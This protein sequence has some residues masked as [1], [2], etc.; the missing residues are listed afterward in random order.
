MK[1]KDQVLSMLQNRAGAYVSGQEIADTLF[2]TRAGIWKAIRSLR[3]EGHVIEAVNNRGYRL[4]SSSDILSEGSIRAHWDSPL[5][6][7]VEDTVESTNDCA[8]AYSR[9]G[10]S[11]EA[12]FVA[13]C[14]TKGRGRRGRAFYSPKDT[15]LYLSILLHPHTFDK[16][17]AITCLAAVSLCLAIEEVTSVTPSIKWVNDLYIGDH[18]IAGI[19][20]EASFS[21]EDNSPEY[22]VVG[23]GLNVYP[24]KEGFPA[25]IRKK[26]GALAEH[27]TPPDNFRT[28][29]CQA[30]LRHFFR[31]LTMPGQEL[32]SLYRS[33]SNLIGHYVCV[34]TYNENA[35]AREYALVTGIDDQYRLSVR[36]EDGTELHLSSGEVSV[37]KY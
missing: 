15:G 26:A 5:P 11:E 1:T 35:R 28:L 25:D 36:Y 13:S 7:F 4:V 33:H 16:T 32:L 31:C 23:M 22:V 27:C 24:P 14:Q 18:K 3:D 9:L 37:V 2:I 8:I 21:I 30:I 10:H 6:L 19:L 17:P 20:T 34:N 29:L 12:V